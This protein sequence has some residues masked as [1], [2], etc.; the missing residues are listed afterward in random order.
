MKN[1]MDSL[2]LWSQWRSL[3]SS[4]WQSLA[5]MWCFRKISLCQT[6]KKKS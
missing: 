3:E 2:H 4:P 5:Y 1:E 6:D